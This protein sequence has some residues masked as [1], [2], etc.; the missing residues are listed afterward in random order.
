MT[1]RTQEERETL[2]AAAT[3]KRR[4]SK[5][6][7]KARKEAAREHV[8]AWAKSS[9]RQTKAVRERDN[10]YL[11]WIRRLP[12]VA[13]LVTQQCSGIIHAAHLRYSDAKYGRVNSGMQSKP[14]DKWCLPLC[15]QHHLHDQHKR[16]ERE[17]WS[18]LGIEPSELCLSLHAA[19][20]A[21]QEGE[22]VIRQHVGKDAA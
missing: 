4:E 9:L 16:N 22:P 11:A 14:S 20:L 13:G 1:L 5:E 7:R 8:K 21:G 15:E 10:L 6:R 18:S 12:C 2:S 17:F 19:F 3:I